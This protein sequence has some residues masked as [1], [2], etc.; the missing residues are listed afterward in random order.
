[1]NVR[2]RS[3]GGRLG[4]VAAIGIRRVD[5]LLERRFRRLGITARELGQKLQEQRVPLLRNCLHP[6]TAAERFR[7]LLGQVRGATACDLKRIVASV[8][9]RVRGY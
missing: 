2:A 1:M 3:E 9:D 7:G 8:R 6:L 4:P 5:A